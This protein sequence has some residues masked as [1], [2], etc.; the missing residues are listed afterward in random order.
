MLF[1]A[2]LLAFLV[3]T[4]TGLSLQ[5]DANAEN[6]QEISLPPEF[7]A[8]LQNISDIVPGAYW[9]VDYLFCM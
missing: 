3:A 9:K 7:T 2:V 1:V 4:S 6:D 8:W 5:G